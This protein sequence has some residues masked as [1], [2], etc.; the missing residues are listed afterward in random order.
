MACG[1]KINDDYVNLRRIWLAD[2]FCHLSANFETNSLMLISLLA[3]AK[4]KS[5]AFIQSARMQMSRK[6]CGPGTFCA[7]MDALKMGG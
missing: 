3:D 1:A 2:M 4:A 6:F 7:C 5:A